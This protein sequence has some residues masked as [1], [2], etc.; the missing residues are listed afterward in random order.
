MATAPTLSLIDPDQPDLG[1]VP[2]HGRAAVAREMA[3]SDEP[4]SKPPAGCWVIPEEGVVSPDTPEAPFAMLGLEAGWRVAV[5]VIPKSGS[6]NR[7]VPADDRGTRSS[8]DAPREAWGAAET[9]SL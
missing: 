7:P 3:R 9:R 1:H 5:T 2:T 4:S 6:S 8:A